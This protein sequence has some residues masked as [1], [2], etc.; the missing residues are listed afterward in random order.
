MPARNA[1]DFI[2]DRDATLAHHHERR[3]PPSLKPRQRRLEQRPRMHLDRARGQAI[4]DHECN[5]VAAA[6]V[7]GE[8]RFGVAGEAP[9]RGSAMRAAV[10]ARN[11][12]HGSSCVCAGGRC[13]RMA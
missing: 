12:A 3:D 7:R 5:I 11:S 8:P 6:G 13:S 4:G 1:R 2:A 9:A 10:S